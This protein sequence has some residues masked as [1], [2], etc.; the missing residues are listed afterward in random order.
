LPCCR[1]KKDSRSK[2]I[3]RPNPKK[4]ISQI[5]AKFNSLQNFLKQLD[6]NLEF[7]KNCAFCS[8]FSKTGL[9]IQFFQH[10]KGKND[11]MPI[12]FYFYQTVS[13]RPNLADFTFKKAKWQPRHD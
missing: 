13:K 3:K 6:E 5:K 9:K 8:D 1:L 10:S 11:Q 4:R 7:L 2:N 12:P